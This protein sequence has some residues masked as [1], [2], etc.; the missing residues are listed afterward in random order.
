MRDGVMDSQ[1]T[2]PNRIRHRVPV[3]V[4]RVVIARTPG[5]AVAQAI[6]AMRARAKDMG[7]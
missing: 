4:V 6:G 7:Q 3:V 1:S 2:T 5:C